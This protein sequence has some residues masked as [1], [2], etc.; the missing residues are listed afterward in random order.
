M[1]AC[2]ER[3]RYLSGAEVTFECELVALEDRFGILR[4]VIDQ[5]WN[6][7]GLTLRPGTV[8]YAFYWTD[9]P[10]NLYWWL[11]EDGQTLGCYF[12]V[13]DLVSLSEREFVWRDLVV[14]ILVLPT[15]QV[16]VID[17]NEVPDGL[18]EEL[19]AYIDAGKR[20]VLRN[21]PI[22]VEAAAAILKTKVNPELTGMVGP[23][24]S[25]PARRESG[26]GTRT[27]L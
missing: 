27:V 3:K 1:T 13:A 21:H 4:Y 26:T 12:N 6:V 11:D 20:Q 18:D 7:E 5:Q 15:G 16:H 9:R 23:G 17:E 25:I 14:D 24:D 8:T 2:L 10:Y 22:I 19:R